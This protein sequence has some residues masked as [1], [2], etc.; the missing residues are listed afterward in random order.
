MTVSDV[1]RYIFGRTISRFVW[2]RL[3]DKGTDPRF[4]T[5]AKWGLFGNLLGFKIGVA[6]ITEWKETETNFPIYL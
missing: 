2:V 6:N 1:S 5:T 4:Q 3:H